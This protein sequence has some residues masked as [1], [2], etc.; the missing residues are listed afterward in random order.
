MSSPFDLH[1]EFR[2]LFDALTARLAAR[3]VHAMA[4]S[5]AQRRLEFERLMNEWNTPLPT[6]VEATGHCL[7]LP[8]GP[9]P[10]RLYR[11]AGR[12]ESLPVLVYLHGGGW[13]F[14]SAQCVESKCRMLALA[15]GIAVASVDYLLAPEHPF[16]AARD[17]IVA[18]VQGLRAL[19]RE[20][21][22]APGHYALG[23]DSSGAHL[24]LSAAIALRDARRPLPAALMLIQGPYAWRSDT[25]SHR[26]LGDGRYG[27]SSSD[28][29]D[30][31]CNYA[32]DPATASDPGVSPL[33]AELTGLPQTLVVSGALDPL[34]DDSRQLASRLAMA[35]VNC[36]YREY[37]RCPHGFTVLASRLAASR[38]AVCEAADFLRGALTIRD[39]PAADETSG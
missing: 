11:P 37:A 7:H 27:L 33:W 32:G 38:Q 21:A 35:G 12:S 26:E 22:I 36:S 30:F 29:D 16:P 9:V 6:G 17:Q 10:F 8:T 19:G 18:Y 23:G 28:M 5:Y 34:R 20:L 13:T 25:R 4:A 14:G 39:D 15:A 1:P 31:W 24:A 3:P 2:V